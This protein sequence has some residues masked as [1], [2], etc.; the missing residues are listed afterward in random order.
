[1]QS[2]TLELELPSVLK[3]HFN[4]ILINVIKKKQRA[5]LEELDFTKFG[6][7]QLYIKSNWQ[8]LIVD[9]DPGIHK[10]IQH[11]L[12][13]L[14][15]ENRS[16]DILHAYSQ[17]EAVE[18][19]KSNNGVSLVMMDVQSQEEG[20]DAIKTIREE[21]EN[22]VI[23]IIIRTTKQ[24]ILSQNVIQEYDICKCM[25][26]DES[27]GDKLYSSVVDALAS[28][29]DHIIIERNR[30]GLEKIIEA[31]GSIFKISS[32]ILFVEGVLTQL[33]SILNLNENF[34]EQKASDAF[35]ATLENGRFKVLA[36]TGKFVMEDSFKIITP[37]A[38]EYLDIAYLNRYS[39]FKDDIYVGYFESSNEH[40]IFLY[41]EGCSKLRSCDR[42]F[43][44]IF[45]HNISVAYENIYLNKE[46]AESQKEIIDKFGE[47]VESKSCDSSKHVNNV[48]K[49]SYILAKA[50]GISEDEANMLKIA[51]PMHD[52]G[53]I[54][55]SDDIL[56]KPDLL[57]K[58]EY[59]EMTKHTKI[60]YEILN[61][62]GR[63]ILK[64][65]AVIAYEHHERWDGKGYPRGLKGEEISVFG[66]ITAIA[67]VFD[68]LLHARVYKEA[69]DMQRVL[70]YIEDESG[71]FFDPK[72][73]ELFFENLESIKSFYKL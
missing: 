29:R 43:I 13:K 53:K 47:I 12:A 68:V 33:A 4:I 64:T 56:M 15:F 3:F 55:I 21:L 34:Q 48:A 46:I 66:R 44:R 32:L 10:D 73:V 5:P 39:Y 7:K 22:P 20:L 51:S 60:G 19:L 8:I 18:I 70:K 57:T 27:G 49:I 52:I 63:K 23:R 38:I 6:G 24:N 14:D 45:S 11:E 61:A 1:M 67:D 30:V 2:L 28:Y 36:S 25:E 31:S 17:D 72:L 59:S 58:E 26:K 41:L 37:K 50:Y 9:E 65:A 69:W 16:I 40:K 62:S 35:F 54:G 42:E 71:K